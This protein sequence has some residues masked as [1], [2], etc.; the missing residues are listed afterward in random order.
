MNVEVNQITERTPFSMNLAYAIGDIHGRDDLLRPLLAA[1]NEDAADSARRFIFLGDIVDRGPD[2]KECMEIVNQTM[3][4]HPGSKFVL[5]NHDE[6]FW[7]AISGILRPD[8]QAAWLE[9]FGGWQTVE[10]YCGGHRPSLPEFTAHF[11]E[12]Y[13]HHL[14]MLQS[15]VDK[16]ETTNF[17]FVHAGVR[18]GFKMA[19]QDPHDLRWIRDGFIEFTGK[20]EK[21]IVHGHTI[22]DSELPEVHGNRI[23]IDTGSYRTGRVSSAVF[24]DDELAGFICAEKIN[25]NPLI[26]RFGARMETQDQTAAKV[27]AV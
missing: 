2:S 8:E 5:G 25:G 21:T 20:F 17:C 4:L 18:P 12:F 7:H 27:T 11:H 14:E 1:I 10:A 24:V 6:R 13:D 26:R 16:V 3:L 19:D 23:A 22:T 15:A 9:D